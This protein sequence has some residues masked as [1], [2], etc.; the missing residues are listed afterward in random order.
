M[1]TS[2][3]AASRRRVS[4]PPGVDRSR[5]MVR[6]LRPSSFHHRPTPSL[7]GPWP[8][9]GSGLVGCSILMTSAPKSP[10]MVAASGPAKRVARSRTRSPCSGVGA[11]RHEACVDLGAVRHGGGGSRALDAQGGGRGGPAEGLRHGPALAEGDGEGADEGVTGAGGVHGGDLGG[12]DGERGRAP[13]RVQAA[14]RAEGD[15]DLG[16]QPQQR[17]GRGVRVGD[18]GEGGRLVLVG[19]QQVD[20][21]EQFGRQGLGGGGGED[22]PYAVAA[23]GFGAVEHGAER[24]FELEQQHVGGGDEGLVAG[25][26]A[27]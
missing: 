24:E 16:D 19:D 8:R 18:A 9:E 25:G 15:H 26:E 11:R 14:R 21:G 17:L 27:R 23:G 5:V 4:R 12:G 13:G 6:L 10:S 3:V 7:S 20:G 2:A 1:I 22:G